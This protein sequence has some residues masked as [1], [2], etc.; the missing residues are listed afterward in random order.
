MACCISIENI[1]TLGSFY[2]L[3]LVKIIAESRTRTS[4]QPL[5]TAAVHFDLD[6]F[7]VGF[8]D[9]FPEPNECSDHTVY[10]EGDINKG[11]NHL[12]AMA[13]GFQLQKYMFKRSLLTV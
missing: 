6:C 10:L 9:Y 4:K 7:K 2:R 3:W 5:S 12:K 13:K 11:F 1:Q 8:I